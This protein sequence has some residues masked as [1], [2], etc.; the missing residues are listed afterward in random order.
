VFSPE[1]VEAKLD[2]FAEEFGWRPQPHSIEDVDEWSKRLEK[3]FETDPKGNIF[4]TRPLTKVEERFIANERACCAASCHYFLTRYYYIK[5]KN[6]I[7]RFTF[8][9]GQWIMWQMLC[10]L[11]RMGVSKMLQILKARQLGISTLAEGIAT[12]H[13]QF[14]PGVAAQIGSADGQ[15]TQIMLGMMT[16]AL[17]QLPVWLPPTQTRAKVASDRA[18]LEFSRIGSLIMVQ[19]GSMRGGMGQGTTPTFV[20]LSEVSQ[21]TDPTSQL[22]EG[23]IKALHEGPELVVMLES[24]GDA[25]HRSAWWWKEQWI[26]NRDNYWA[27]RAKFLPVFLPWHTTP[28]LYPGEAWMKKFPMPSG[29]GPNDDT[30][31]H[32]RRAE[33]YVRNTEMLKRLMG[34]E[35]AMPPDQQW[36]WEFNH[37]DHKRRRVEKS[38]YRQMPSDDYEA[39]LGENDKVYS[40]AAI[41]VVTKSVESLDKTPVYMLVGEDIPEKREPKHDRVWYGEDAPP[42]LRTTWISKKG[43]PLEWMFVPLKPESEKSFNPLEKFLIWETRREGYDYSIGW[44]TGT[45]VGGDRTAASVRR[46]GH[47]DEPCVQVAEFA[48]DSISEAEIYAYIA[49]L[50]S[51]YSP[52]GE[53]PHPKLCIEMKRKFGDLPY[54]MTRQLGFR[55]W[56][57]W[58]GGFD[59]KTFEERVGKRGRV[60][61]FTNEWSRPLL[62]SAY[63]YGVENGWA[64]VKSKW[65]AQEIQD[66]EQRVTASGKTRVDHE[67]GGHNDRVF[68]DAQAYWTMNQSSVMIERAKMRYESPKDSGIVIMHG[69]AVQT[70]EIP[71]AKWFE[72]RMRA[73]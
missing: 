42:R 64:E 71:G 60:G 5:F 13:S 27:G 55:R 25:S 18:M 73:R 36:F 8:R 44:D 4:Q 6:K 2:R 39:L 21:F 63:Q 69:P 61:W 9:Q 3:V 56:H 29:W 66:L 46:H 35:W 62:L 15:K 43:T 51:L 31:A 11:D 16:L 67:S 40:E 58:G 14:V 19:P 10:E 72:S 57:E 48:S 37:E 24:T 22:D 70:I 41:E 17:D 23:L 68:A 59:R 32:V 54:H 1:V 65:L 38:W 26:A 47:P 30:V 34:A 50:A 49:A 53:R 45:G 7:A 52:C 28:E 12:H 33:A 20:H